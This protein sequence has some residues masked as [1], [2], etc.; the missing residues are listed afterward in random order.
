MELSLNRKVVIG[1]VATAV[2]AAAGGTYAATRHSDQASDRPAG[3]L[4]KRQAFLDD[5]ISGPCAQ[6]M[7]TAG[8]TPAPT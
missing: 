2:L 6:I 5:V 3:L 8:F 1:A 7:K 4:A